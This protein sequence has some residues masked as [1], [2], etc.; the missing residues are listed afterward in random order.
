MP[1]PLGHEYAADTMLSL[2]IAALGL[3]I[4][5]GT[6]SAQQ[7]DE[8]IEEIVTTGSRI[9][10]DP[11]L[12][13][14]VAVQSVSAEDIQL[15]GKVDIV[16]V[17]REI[18]ALITSETSD[19]SS[20]L[21]GSDFDSNESSVLDLSGES[22]LQ[23]RGMGLERTLVLVDGRRHVAGSPGNAAV[24]INT[25]P[26]PLIERVEVLTGGASAI[27]GADAVTGV[28]NFIMKDDYEGFEI[29]AQGGISSEGD[30]EDYRLG[31]VWGTNFADDRGNFTIALDY[32]KRESLQMGDRSFTADNAL[33]NGDEGNHPDMRFQQGDIGGATPLFAQYFSTVNGLYPYGLPIPSAD[34]FVFG[35]NA[36]FPA[37]PITPA[38]LSADELALIDRAATSPSR[39]I[40][41]F[42]TFSISSEGGVI[43]P[44]NYIDPVNFAGGAL[45]GL[46]LD[47]NGVD[48]CLDSHQGFNAPIAVAGGCWHIDQG[49]VVRPYQDGLIAGSFNQ[50]GGDGV[51]ANGYSNYDLLPDDQRFNINLS[52]HYDITDTLT[53][54]GEA[55]FVSQ[56][57]D[58]FDSADGFYDL[59]YIAPDNPFIPAAL[60]PIA[61]AT[62]GFRLTRDPKDFPDSG[63]KVERDMTRFILGLE[64][65]F[66][67]GWGFE[68][69]LNRGEATIDSI[70][71]GVT[72]M[73]RYF[74]S[75]DVTTD[76]GGNPICRS[77]LDGSLYTTTPFDIPT[78]DP[79]FFTFNP[80]DGTCI[81]YNLMEGPM[82][83]SDAV[84]D[85]FLTDQV[86]TS[87]IDQT[88]FQGI[89]NGDLPFGLDAG[90]VA[91]AA[92][93]EFRIERS[94]TVFDSL[95]KGECPIDTVDCNAGDLLTDLPDFR[96]TSLVF[97][98]RFVSSDTRG[99]YSVW[100]LFGEVEIPLLAGQ[101]FAEELTFNA[102]ARFSQYSNVGDTLTW[103]TGLVWAPVE[104]IRFRTTVSHS[105]RAPNIAELFNPVLAAT[106]RPRD[107]CQQS[108]ID[109]LLANDPARAAIREAN[110]V[111][112][113]IPMGFVDPLSARVSGATSG[114]PDLTE[115]EADTFTIGFV[116]TPTFIE[117]VTVSVD[118]WDIEI[119][120]AIAFVA[121]QDIVNSCYDSETFPNQFCDQFRRVRDPL[122]AQFLGFDFIQQT[123]LNFGKLESSGIDFTASYAFEVG[124]TGVDLGVQA[125][126]VD[127]LDRFFDPV[128][129]NVVDP[130]L[131]ELRRPELSGTVWAGFAVGPFYGRWSSFYQD[132]QALR[133]V[134]IESA[135]FEFGPAGFSDDFWSHDVSL[136]WDFNDSLRFYGGVNNVTDEKPFI[137]ET[138]Y[139]VNPRG[140]FFFLGVNYAI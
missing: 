112:D 60:Q 79:G 89:V 5:G 129:P 14:P 138:A 15:S 76:G 23:L 67:N 131:G 25:I 94:A 78:F 137:T 29:S 39:L 54:F 98:P 100:E 106:F 66:D 53:I 65:E 22:V 24:D 46:D 73:D 8:A 88:V 117:G 61:A 140:R 18:P 10:R 111:A 114:N 82:S 87:K 51:H 125:A 41:Q 93:T 110:C 6:A 12:G 63:T 38:D 113:G 126:K 118:F 43:G 47:N 127:K 92:G 2:G 74:A 42:L 50:F 55:K 64:G 81:P 58:R 97:D 3:G 119:T 102:A 19:S 30:G 107:P 99:D 16:E 91:F 105:V 96:Q 1:E 13:A 108:E 44:E 85:W 109:A 71:R 104:D 116:L 72:I 101:T 7:Q 139:P 56:E 120:D 69:S 135:A 52:G 28:V 57:T 90:N 40:G 75:I 59:H 86:N 34:D 11:N 80:M 32:R 26:Q 27:Y 62:G 33:A 37:T 9:A 83:G 17:V 35:Y 49:G 103:Q 136:S 132:S 31:A 84:K 130:E 134:E 36:A 20:S 77:E 70:N 95:T 4:S 121:A 21:I 123:Q 48:D 115:E 128:N 45:P 133:D 68:F 122:S 124:A